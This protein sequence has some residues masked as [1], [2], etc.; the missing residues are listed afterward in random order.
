MIYIRGL[1]LFSVRPYVI[2]YQV[3]GDGIHVVRIVHGARDFPSLFC[4]GPVTAPGTTGS[5]NTSTNHTT[6][7]FPKPCPH[8]L[9]TSNRS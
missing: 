7:Q 8:Q 2:I 9:A 3:A 4:A 6:P 5:A 1:R